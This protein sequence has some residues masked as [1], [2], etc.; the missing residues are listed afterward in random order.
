MTQPLRTTTTTK[1]S[2]LIPAVASASAGL[3][4]LAGAALLAKKLGISF[5]GT[6]GPFTE[7]LNVDVEAERSDVSRE[8]LA[9]VSMDMF[10]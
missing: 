10:S 2:V 7:D 6:Q 5:T 1:R 4:A 3:I 8:A 9:S